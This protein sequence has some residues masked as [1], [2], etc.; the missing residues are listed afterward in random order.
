M[1]FGSI[2]WPVEE[3]WLKGGEAQSQRR[4]EARKE[5]RRAEKTEQMTAHIR[6]QWQKYTHT[7]HGTSSRKT[8]KQAKTQTDYTEAS[9]SFPLLGYNWAT[10]WSKDTNEKTGS[11]YLPK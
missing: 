7:K 3:E 1:Y 11:C 2:L 6:E 9:P 5:G 4:R 10:G 8:E